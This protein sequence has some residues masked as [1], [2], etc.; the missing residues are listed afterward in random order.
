MTIEE[1]LKTYLLTI[2]ELTEKIGQKVF[3]MS[4]DERTEPPLVV[5]SKIAGNRHHELDFSSPLI[6]V[7]YYDTDAERARVGAEIII[8]AINGYSGLMG[9]VYVSQG[10]YQNDLVLPPDEG[11]YGAPVDIRLSHREG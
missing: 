3:F 7:T 9:T 5:F 2:P 6:Q 8:Q 11:V 10:I 4:A 1:A